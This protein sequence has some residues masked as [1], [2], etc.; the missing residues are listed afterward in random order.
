[1]AIS[2][3][4]HRKGKMR[5]SLQ[6][7]YKSASELAAQRIEE[8][9]GPRAIQFL[10]RPEIMHCCAGARALYPADRKSSAAI[11]LSHRPITGVSPAPKRLLF[12]SGKLGNWVVFD[13]SATWLKVPANNPGRGGGI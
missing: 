4:R 9:R 12:L 7:G 1:M 6:P 11:H 5:N 3:T 2:M 10:P 8:T 13:E